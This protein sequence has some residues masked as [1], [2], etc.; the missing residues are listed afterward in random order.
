MFT[1]NFR[2]DCPRGIMIKQV[3][4][5]LRK[6]WIVNYMYRWECRGDDIGIHIHIR[7]EIK[8]GKNTYNCKREMWNTFKECV[9]SRKH[10]N[11]RY[12]NRDDAFVKYVKGYRNGSKKEHWD[13][14]EELNKSMN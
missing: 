5:C 11:C 14:D 13:L 6:K 2:D 12:S 1:I 7:C 4:K 3:N 8:N 10:V 9:G